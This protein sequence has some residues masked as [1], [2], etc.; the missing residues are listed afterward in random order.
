MKHIVS[1]LILKNG[2]RGLI[3]DVPGAQ[4]MSTQFHFRAGNRFVRDRSIYETAHI[5]EHMAFG[6]NKRC[7]DSHEY[8]A[9][10]TKNGAYHNAYTS[11]T[12]MVYE[13]ECAKFE[14]DRILGLQQAAITQPLFTEE[15]FESERGNVK[16]ELTG[17]LNIPERLLWPKISQ[18]LGEDILTYP[19]RLAVLPDITLT[20]V[21]EHYKRTHRANNLR[22]VIAGDFHREHGKL[23][24]I[25]NS[26]ELPS[27]ERL[28]IEVDELHSAPSFLIR[29]KD[30]PNLTFGL[31]YVVKR[32]LSDEEDNSMDFLNHILTGTLRSRILGAARKKGVV[33]SMFSDTSTN[34]HTSTWDFGAQANIDTVDTLVDIIV[35]EISA[36]LRGELDDKELDAAKSYALGRHQMGAQTVGRINGWYAGRYFFDGKI[37][38]FMAQPEEINAVSKETIIKSAR[39]FF[40]DPCWTFGAYGSSEI[41]F[42][43][44][45][46][47]KLE[48]L[49]GIAKEG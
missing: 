31:T 19:E 46:A 38:D 42:V 8:E 27:G 40:E 28:P 34:E 7:R 37:E 45:L 1:E 30:A 18:E 13:A 20:D 11:N 33:Y 25:L 32:R 24:E 9:E 15:E 14:W 5:M 4:V 6:A 16:S 36:I 47:S 48:P 22:F 21:R 2:A 10:F 17:Y 26:W 3:I 35:K 39:K 29:R 23:E 44:G 41:A 12:S 49:F 43:R